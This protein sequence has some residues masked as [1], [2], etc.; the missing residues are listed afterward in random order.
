MFNTQKQVS[1]KTLRLY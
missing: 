1:K